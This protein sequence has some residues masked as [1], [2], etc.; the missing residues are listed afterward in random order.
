VVMVGCE[1]NLL[2]AWVRCGVGTEGSVPVTVYVWV[3]L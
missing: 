1:G 3:E 2:V